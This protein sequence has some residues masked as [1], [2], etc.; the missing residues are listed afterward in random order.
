MARG[1]FTNVL[2][3]AD[4]AVSTS[5]DT[6][7]INIGSDTLGLGADAGL[8]SAGSVSIQFTTDSI[9]TYIAPVVKSDLSVPEVVLD[10]T[11]AFPV[12]PEG[13]YAVGT[14]IVQMNLPVLS[15]LS[16]RFGATA[17]NITNIRT[18]VQ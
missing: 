14:H 10:D 15:W 12:V 8:N 13:P 2:A 7:F 18:N 11:D 4:L 17:A 9:V 6:D 5:A 16:T 1:V 3:N